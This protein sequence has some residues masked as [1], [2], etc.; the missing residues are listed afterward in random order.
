LILLFLL[1][2]LAALALSII[3][4]STAKGL[5]LLTAVIPLEAFATIEAGFTIPPSYVLLVILLIGS[6]FKGESLSI[7]FPGARPVLAY[8][9]IAVI[10]TALAFSGAVDIPAM[11][12]D[13]AAR[14]RAGPLRSPI[15]LALIFFHFSLFF[16]IAAR[17]KSIETADRILRMHLVAGLCLA[18]VGIYQI[19]AFTFDLPLKDLTWSI[20]AVENSSAYTYSQVRYYSAGVAQF[21]SRATFLESLHFASYL[22]SVVPIALALWVGRSA[23]TR[24][25]FGVFTSPLVAVLGI[26]ALFLTMSRSGWA[27]FAVASLIIAFRLS[28]RVLFIHVPLVAIILAGGVLILS[29]VGFFPESMSSLGA[30]ISG[31]LN[32]DGI[33]LDPRVSYFLVLIESFQQHPVLGVGA[34]NF[35]LIAPA[36]IGSDTIHSAHGLLWTALADFGMLGFLGMLSVF[37]VILFKLNHAISRCS[38]NADRIIMVGLFAAICGLMAQSLFCN[39]R[40]PFYLMLLMGLSTVYTSQAAANRSDRDPELG[41]QHNRVHSET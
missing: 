18:L 33:L 32:F 2:L 3:G 39:D 15:Q 36:M 21:S 35:A 1:P 26:I 8:L 6:I 10:A 4:R 13:R 23:G 12:F 16:L 11:Q 22:N 17:V 29:K 28:P 38:V 27:A 14:F 25:R 40:P 7:R 9:G 20:D 41:N 19:A 5:V 31:R 30:V 24:E 37:S 34:G